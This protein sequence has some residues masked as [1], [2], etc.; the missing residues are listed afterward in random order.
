[1]AQLDSTSVVSESIVAG[2]K[3]P[4][5]FHI[6]FNGRPVR[7]R[8]DDTVASALVRAGV[9]VFSRSL[10][11]HR[12]RGYFCGT[13]R[14]YSCM[15]RVNGIPGV[16]TCTTKAEPG[17]A[18]E[19]ERGF[20]SARHD[21]MSLLDLVFKKELDYRS[22]SIRP[23]VLVPFYQ[24][25]VRRMA[26]SNQLP[27]KEQLYPAVERASCDVAIVG[28][29]VSGSVAEARIKGSGIRSITTVDCREEAGRMSLATAF[30]FF[31]DGSLGV[32]M[33]LGIRVVNAKAVLLATGRI[34][35]GLPIVNSD[36][37]GTML[38]E[39]VHRLVIRG[40]PP[41][42]RAFPIGRN[43]LKER[44]AKV[45]QGIGTEVVGDVEDPRLVSRIVGR[46][47][48]SGVE[49]KVQGRYPNRV[50]CDLAVLFGELMP[51]VALA[52]QAGCRLQSRSGVVSVEVAAGGASSVPGVFAC[53][54]V[55][56]LSRPEDRMASGEMVASSIVQMLGAG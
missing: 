48:V 33:D 36:I 19:T 30:T 11:F 44:T 55:T 17:M 45:L 31:E 9:Y 7:A 1:M 42:K 46:A 35:T 15:M 26:S 3:N 27:D 4:E 12:P 20:P 29:G 10:K 34:E 21:V 39:A 23:S 52:Q 49:L 5:E 47:R 18:V 2:A 6:H 37:P 38:P 16:R 25:L 51:S 50:R 32:L 8:A 56:G 22:R 40:I 24:S 41:G 43:E 14:C 53:G 54:G 28:Q 13:G